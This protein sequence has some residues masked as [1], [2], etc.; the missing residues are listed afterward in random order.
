[1]AFEWPVDRTC[2]KQLPDEP[3]DGAPQD[4]VDKYLAAVF[5]MNAATDLAVAVLFRLSGRVYGLQDVVV[6]PCPA[7]A[8]LGLTGPRT[9]P[10]SGVWFDGQQWLD[11][12][13]G[14]G[15]RCRLSGPRMAHLQSPAASV[16]EVRING[17]TVDPAGYRLEGNVLYRI[18]ANW[19]SQNLSRPAGEN[20]TWTVAYKRGV[21]VSDYIARL[22]GQLAA[23][24]QKAC[25]G[26]SC[27]LPSN[28]KT[29]TRQGVSYQVYDP[30]DL[31]KNRNTGIANIDAWLASG[32]P[33]K[34][35]Q[36]PVVL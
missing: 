4:Q 33:G 21:P 26:D 7:P 31:F 34:L 15:S 18:G 24:F 12:T 17:A 8:G 5:T 32:N 36:P 13:C 19:P 27:S 2:M 3:A 30:T 9:F 29:V 1:M 22:T 23:E 20:G 35:M 25:S 11:Y 28:V 16:T 10:R 6:R 14:C